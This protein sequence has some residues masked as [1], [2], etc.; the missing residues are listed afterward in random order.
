MC[1]PAVGVAMN[2]L[3]T[4]GGMMGQQQQAQA[5]YQAAKNQRQQVINEQRSRLTLDTARYHRKQ[6]DRERADM[7][8]V[9]ASEEGYLGNQRKYNEKVSAFM[10]NKQN[11]LIKAMEAGG[12]I[13]AKMGPGGSAMMAQQALAASTGRDTAMGLASLRSAA[14]QLSA[15]NRGIRDKLQGE[16]EANFSAIGDKPVQ[17]FVPPEVAKPAGPNP[18]SIAS[19]IGGSLVEGFGAMQSANTLPGGQTMGMMGGGVPGVNTSFGLPSPVNPTSTFNSN[20]NF[21]F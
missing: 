4:A 2:V 18:L 6:A 19:A 8:A 1:A 21:G 20:F 15:D 9:R 12:T 11:R 16:Y 14:T 7:S 5:Q 3:G 17:G 13:G 10:S